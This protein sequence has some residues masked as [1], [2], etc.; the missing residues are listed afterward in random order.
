MG[1]FFFN[2]KAGL[3]I[4]KKGEQ[5]MH[6]PLPVVNKIKCL[7]QGQTYFMGYPCG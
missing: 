3:L 6:H 5:T 2:L 1:H 7:A 4:I